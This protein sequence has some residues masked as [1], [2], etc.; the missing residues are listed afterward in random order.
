MSAKSDAIKQADLIG[1]EFFQELSNVNYKIDKPDE[2]STVKFRTYT[3]IIIPSTYYKWTSEVLD[4]H[5]RIESYSIWILVE[6]IILSLGKE[7]GPHWNKLKYSGYMIQNIINQLYNIKQRNFNVALD[8]LTLLTM[9]DMVHVVISLPKFSKNPKGSASRNTIFL[10]YD[11][12]RLLHSYVMGAPE[13]YTTEYKMSHEFSRE[14]PLSEIIN[15]YGVNNY[16]T[17][18]ITARFPTSIQTGVSTPPPAYL[19]PGEQNNRNPKHCTSSMTEVSKLS[20]DLEQKLLEIDRERF[21]HR[22]ELNKNEETIRKQ[23]EHNE[24]LEK[25]CKERLDH[26]NKEWEKQ[27]QTLNETIKNYQK[28]INKAKETYE[29]REVLLKV[30]E[31]SK[32]KNNEDLVNQIKKRDEEIIRLKTDFESE[33]QRHNRI[34]K[35][36]HDQVEKEKKGLN[37]G[38][39][40]K[41][42]EC[43]QRE[44]ILHGEINN[45]KIERD[46]LKGQLADADAKCLLDITKSKQESEDQIRKL[47]EELDRLTEDNAE[48]SRFQNNLGILTGA[49]STANDAQLT[50][51]T[52]RE[53]N[54]Q[55]NREEFEEQKSIWTQQKENEQRE[56]QRMQDESRQM[57]EQ[58]KIALAQAK[59]REQKSESIMKTNETLRGI[60]EQRLKQVEQRENELNEKENKY[61]SRVQALKTGEEQIKTQTELNKK[62]EHA[63]EIRS[64]ELND[65]QAEFAERETKI[66]QQLNDISRREDDLIKQK[67]KVVNDQNFVQKQLETNNDERE[68]LAAQNRKITEEREEIKQKLNDIENLYYQIEDEKNQARLF[69]EEARKTGQE[70]EKKK[71]RAK[72]EYEEWV[73]KIQKIIALLINLLTYLSDSY[74]TNDKYINNTINQLTGMLPDEDTF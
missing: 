29:Q 61:E 45:L 31:N 39:S 3:F 53:Q 20:K 67:N 42:Y 72:K 62:M 57:N 25:E 73:T 43:K 74:N 28:E 65:K 70:E 58:A 48:L 24:N 12:L 16:P 68:H 23:K 14:Y 36:L 21:K 18:V 6:T 22:E 9:K 44:A 11:T 71:E 15:Q 69:V 7:Y 27:N 54:L 17:E 40:Q 13:S 46:N 4:H 63:N 33:K 35:D 8:W 19:P 10:T 51:I 47:H 38:I 59:E 32:N 26:V 34:E 2:A 5:R 55:S 1:R 37:L 60:V 64:K 41:E 66:Q 50:Y 56:I 49:S 30:L 52:E